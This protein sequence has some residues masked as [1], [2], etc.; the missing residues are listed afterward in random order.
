MVANRN[1]TNNRSLHLH[2]ENIPPCHIGGVH[3]N[4][5]AIECIGKSL[6]PWTSSNRKQHL[7]ETLYCKNVEGNII[8]LKSLVTRQ[9]LYYQGCTIIT[10]C[11]SC[12][13]KLQFFIWMVYI[14]VLFL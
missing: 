11:D 2:Y 6:M 9:S 14:T 3:A 4:D 1:V 10:D 7:I 5:V 8:S 12:S 13:G